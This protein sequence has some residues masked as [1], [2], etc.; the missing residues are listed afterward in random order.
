MPSQFDITADAL[1][2]L[3]VRPGLVRNIDASVMIE[4]GELGGDPI[5]IGGSGRNLVFTDFPAGG[6]NGVWLYHSPGKWTRG[7][8]TLVVV[9][10]AG[11][12]SDET[13]VVA[14]LATGAPHGD[15]DSTVYEKHSS[16]RHSQQWQQLNFLHLARFPP[17]RC[18]HRQEQRLRSRWHP[19]ETICGS[20]RMSLRR[21]HCRSILPQV[22][23]PYP[24]RVASWQSEPRGHRMIPLGTMRQQHTGGL[25]T[26]PP[27]HPARQIQPHRLQRQTT[28]PH[29]RR[30]EKRT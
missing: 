12:I 26:I 28:T 25:F 5:F 6:P 14:T 21:G 20:G 23:P 10:G 11:S 18:P 16:V 2:N 13:D 7:V 9:A 29:P 27:R 17:L 3:Y 4:V 24:M 8:Y 19:Q 22:P 1:G 30:R 15:Y